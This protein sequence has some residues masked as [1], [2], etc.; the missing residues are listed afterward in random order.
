MKKE[1]ESMLSAPIGS[2]G[3][4]RSWNVAG[5]IPMLCGSCPAAGGP[6][7][8]EHGRQRAYLYRTCIKNHGYRIMA[9]ETPGTTEQ[10]ERSYSEYNSGGALSF[11]P[12]KELNL[13]A[14]YEEV[15]ERFKRLQGERADEVLN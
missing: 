4:A 7:P 12:L 15:V 10:T 11:D 1:R 6:T 2:K 3:L 13:P 8:V 14:N 9:E 5:G